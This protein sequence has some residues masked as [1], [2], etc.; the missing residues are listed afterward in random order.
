MVWLYLWIV[1][2][3]AN[4]LHSP[5]PSL[6]DH[7]YSLPIVNQSMSII[8]VQLGVTLF[9]DLPR[10]VLQSVDSRLPDKL[11]VLHAD[12]QSAHRASLLHLLV[13]EQFPHVADVGREVA[14]RTVSQFFCQN[15]PE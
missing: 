10:H 9:L 12:L 14:L 15:V 1:E 13:L 5:L 2:S 11:D 4:A 3:D 6:R 8:L 7:Q